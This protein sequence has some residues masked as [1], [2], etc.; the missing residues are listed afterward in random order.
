MTNK[1]GQGNANIWVTANQSKFRCIRE[2]CL[3]CILSR[4]TSYGRVS[5]WRFSGG[6][7]GKRYD[8]LYK[9]NTKTLSGTVIA[10]M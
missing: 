5:I 6:G 7:L 4:E 3:V 9:S 2:F 1:I 10:L 8:A